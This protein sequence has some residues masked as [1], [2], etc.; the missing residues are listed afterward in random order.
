MLTAENLTLVKNKKTVFCNISFSVSI[1]SAL[2]IKG[3]NGSGKTSFLKILAGIMSKTSGNIL[4]GGNNID[5]FRDDFNG[6]LQFIGHKNFLNQQLSVEQNLKFFA[7]LHDSELALPSAL[8]FFELEKIKH[9]KVKTLSA[10][11]QKRVMLA[12][13]LACPT[14]IW[15]L[16]EPT[17][18]LDQ[19]GKNKLYHLIQTRIK[20]NGLVIISCHNNFFD[21]IGI[22][23]N[24]E[25]FHDYNK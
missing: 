2:I 20:E 13:L 16:D 6:D 23:I 19:E 8:N 12:K 4:W 15:L 5:N 17:V 18:N 14:T 21:K 11:W 7:K 9:Q 3:K 25:D 1:S 10:G 24:L 22:E